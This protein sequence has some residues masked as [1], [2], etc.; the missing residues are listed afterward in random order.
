[1][2]SN[3]AQ[4]SIFAIHNESQEKLKVLDIFGKSVI[5]STA[6]A[7]LGV[8]HNSPCPTLCPEFHY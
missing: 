2:F 8:S 6:G 1:M 7:L 4:K 5:F 3:M